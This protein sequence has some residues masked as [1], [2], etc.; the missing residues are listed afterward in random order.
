MTPGTMPGILPTFAS[1]TCSW[2]TRDHVCA[3]FFYKMIL[4]N[5]SHNVAADIARGF[6]DCSVEHTSCRYSSCNHAVV[7]FEKIAPAQCL[8]CWA[9]FNAIVCIRFL[10]LSLIEKLKNVGIVV[11]AVACDQ[12][13]TNIRLATEVGVSID[14]L[15]FQVKNEP[16]YFF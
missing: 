12:G 16:A 8:H 5:L 2:R 4:K 15:C 9:H 10:P 11:K 13:Y 3:L 14:V 7:N 1:Q 6:T